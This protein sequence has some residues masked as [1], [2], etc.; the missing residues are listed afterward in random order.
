MKIGTR[1]SLFAT[2]MVA[3]TTVVVMAISMFVM[4]RSLE[5][6]A[7]AMQESRIK[8]LREIISAKGP[9]FRLDKN[10]LIVGDYV[11][12]G[13]FEIPDKLKELC[14]GTATI[15]MGDTRISTNIID[16]NGKRA[17]GTR[18][19]GA[20]LE[21]VLKRGHSYRGEAL[22]LGEKYFTAYDP[23]KD[24]KNNVIGILYVGVKKRDYFESF[25]HLS[26]I[27]G[28]VTLVA[29]VLAYGCMWWLGQKISRPLA[30]MAEAMGGS[31]LAMRIQVESEDELGQAANAFNNYNAKLHQDI[32]EVAGFAMRVA[33]GSTELAA[34]ADE[35]SRAV[36][37]IANVSESLKLA[38]DQVMGA[39]EQLSGSARE[40]A[41]A[42][43]AS[44]EA[45]HG[46]VKDVARS[47]DAGTHTVQGMG[48][49]QVVTAKIVAA[50]SV[51]Q[52]IAR[53]TNLLSLNAAIEA[54]KAGQHGKGFA[55]VAEEVRKLA[56]RSRASA[57]E[58][59]G[60]IEQTQGA[61]ETGVANVQETMGALEAIDARIRDIAGQMERVS[62]QVETQAGT[63]GEV[64]ARMSETA[65][66]LAQ[67]AAATHELA[68]TVG[69]ISR[70]SEDLSQ[71]AE[72]LKALVSG[73][74]L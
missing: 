36:N 38:G 16:S 21:V 15:F 19:Q 67:N 3:L 7:T 69:E 48:D 54:A 64:S 24:V 22:I 62:S 27:V 65:Q 49:I 50:V 35:M 14:G 11:F 74:R 63:F 12:N 56:E 72:G 68:A 73:F 46:A 57:V 34:S 9:E 45:S 29:L 32:R 66:G 60:M 55:V 4:Y 41:S 20:A 5:A 8:T 53:Q 58:I 40:V 23:I 26:W 17:I 6:Q 61:V 52:D 28:G 42:I 47:A 25:Y 44:D 18:L 59:Q 13:N 33:S 10:R 30:R 37:D 43:H 39:M 31:D 2:G 1:I 71:V 51:I 70:T